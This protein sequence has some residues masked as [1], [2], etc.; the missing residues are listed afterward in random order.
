MAGFTIRPRLFAMLAFAALASILAVY[1]ADFY[2]AST[3]SF[4]VGKDVVHYHDVSDASNFTDVEAQRPVTFAESVIEKRALTW[5]Q[6]MIKGKSLFRIMAAADTAYCQPPSRWTDYADLPK[7][8]WRKL[9]VELSNTERNYDYLMASLIPNTIDMSQPW[10]V[11]IDLRLSP[12]LNKIVTWLHH[13]RS[14]VLY[15]PQG[16]TVPIPYIVRYWASYINIFNAADGVI[17]SGENVGPDAAIREGRNPR[18]TGAVI[19]LKQWSDVV[20]LDWVD[21]CRMSAKPVRGLRYLVRSSIFGADVIDTIFR[22]SNGGRAPVAGAP[23]AAPPVWAHKRRYPRP[24]DERDLEF[25]TTSDS[26][27]FFALLGT[28]QGSGVVV[29]RPACAAA[30]P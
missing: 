20:F 10:P 16:S 29:P 13:A 25:G 21:Q 2:P 27:I 12:A 23:P 3:N 17:V 14:T 15:K 7:Y 5:D 26:S 30:R 6:A 28:P 4:A 22:A 19:P 8:G 24:V 9:S 11:G 1:I 18:F